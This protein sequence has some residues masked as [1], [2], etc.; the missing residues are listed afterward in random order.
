[1]KLKIINHECPLCHSDIMILK[2]TDTFNQNLFGVM[3]EVPSELICPDCGLTLNPDP[4]KLVRDALV[5][6]F[7]SIIDKIINEDDS[8][9]RKVKPLW[10]AVI[11]SWFI[12]FQCTGTRFN[13]SA[14]VTLEHFKKTYKNDKIT[15]EST[16]GIIKYYEDVICTHPD[17]VNTIKTPEVQKLCISLIKKYS[18]RF[19]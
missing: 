11:L 6:T 10:S 14:Q 17:I 8:I 7:K 4:T 16:E 18:K 13:D 15:D 5:N 12:A 19:C 1:M 9:E 3:N 2:F